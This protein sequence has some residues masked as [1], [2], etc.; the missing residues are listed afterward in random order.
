M[1]T[2]RPP[3]RV[4][5]G[6]VRADVN[7]GGG[8]GRD[9]RQTYGRERRW[10]FD[11]LLGALDA[12]EECELAPTI[13]RISR[14]SWVAET[15]IPH[16]APLYQHTGSKFISRQHHGNR[17]DNHHYHRDTYLSRVEKKKKSS[18]RNFRRSVLINN[19]FLLLSSSVR[20]ARQKLFN[21]P[22][23]N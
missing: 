5:S 9:A 11:W 23:S 22:E 14:S 15:L 12:V 17:R 21:L 1:Q 4:R 10:G 6:S 13:A 19:S 8:A 2:R 20:P 3:D 16:A 7:D 18:D